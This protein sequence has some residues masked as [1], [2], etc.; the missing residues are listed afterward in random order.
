MPYFER[1]GVRLFYADYPSAAGS[2][3]PLTL[4]LVHGLWGAAEGW[5]HQI[6]ALR[7]RYRTVAVDLRGHG[8]SGAPP[9]G[10]DLGDHAEDLAALIRHA[11]LTPVVLLAHSMGCSVATVLAARHPDLVHALA[12]VDPDY[13]GDPGEREWLA[14]LADDLEG[15]DADQV[16]Q[17][18]VSDRFHAPATPGHL[19]A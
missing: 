12:L 3:P 1:S 9:S 8:R 16:A 5:I 19:R 6:P 17:D 10:Y 7:T 15:P 13:A 4:L 2:R 14:R 11:G 18:L